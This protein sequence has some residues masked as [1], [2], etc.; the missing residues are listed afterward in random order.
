VVGLIL[1]VQ[2]LLND[3]PPILQTPVLA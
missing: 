1:I 3:P 2:G